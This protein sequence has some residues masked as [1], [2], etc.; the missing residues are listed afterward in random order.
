VSRGSYSVGVAH[1]GNRISLLVSIII[2]TKITITGNSTAAT[3][4]VATT[5]TTTT[6]TTRTFY[7]SSFIKFLCKVAIFDHLSHKGITFNLFIHKIYAN[8]FFIYVTTPS[9]VRIT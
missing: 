2:T 3:T 9:V 5:T 7:T 1:I 4:E 8:L 6:T